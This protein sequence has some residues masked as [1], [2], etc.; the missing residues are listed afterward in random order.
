MSKVNLWALIPIAVVVLMGL[1][2]AQKPASSETPLK[3]T[4]KSLD[5]KPLE[6]VAVS[7]RFDGTTNV[8]TSVFTARD[9]G[10]SFPPL[11][12]PLE[13]GQYKVWAQAVGF[14]AGR[15]G[16]K[17]SAG[18]AVEQNFALKPLQDFSKQLSGAEWMA[19][20]PS[21]TP[22]DRRLTRLLGNNCMQCHPLNFVLQNRFDAAGWASIVD[23]MAVISHDG[24]YRPDAHPSPWI[25]GYK[26]EM[27]AYLARVRG[28]GSELTY[29]PL[30]RATGEATQ[31]VVTEFDIFPGHLP[32]V[33]PVEN[34]S[35]WSLGTPA[36]H[37]NA[38]AHDAVVDQNGYVWFTDNINP[39]RTIGKLDPRTGRITDYAL[40][41]E[42][43]VA[44]ATHDG[45]VDQKGDIWISSGGIEFGGGTVKFDPR[46]EK[47]HQF[48]K[49]DSLP[50]CCGSLMAIDSK[51]NVWNGAN[52]G[53]IRKVDPKSGIPY[54][55]P[56]PNRKGGA[57]KL[58][59]KTGEYTF[60]RAISPD[61]RNYGVAIDAEDNAWFTQPGRNQLG[62][63]NA[64]N[65]EVGEVNLG[66][67]GL[68]E[69]DIEHTALDRELA[70]K[71]EPTAGQ[72]PP[73][74]KTPRRQA[75]DKRG[76]LWVALSSASRLAKIDIHT[77]KVTEYPMP[78]RYSWPYKVAVDKNHMLWVNGMN[79][80][81]IF[82]FNPF[83]EQWTSYPLPTL[84]TESRFI[85]V[86]NSTD[87]PTVWLPSFRTNKLIRVQFRTG[88]VTRTASR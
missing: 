63:V 84:G 28:P 61:A 54:S 16:A 25:H 13:E 55:V 50:R 42:N 9:G 14:E 41:G 82:K 46:T 83:T 58:N 6:G 60:Y 47:F 34:G 66:P 11:V 3:G 36:R 8:T 20:L 76:N 31:I 87:P 64:R 23:L 35:D 24:F 72:G 40:R 51:G 56:D 65:G 26:E 1:S 62:V 4:V 22:Q 86:D 88:A 74:Q 85:S 77:R 69:D 18:K 32:G 70:A 52:A 2:P 67:L 45:A 57:M 71:F 53:S 15:S 81:R 5:G 43:N 38:A 68:E 44:M 21:A 37:E 48:P 39:E 59:P 30:P 12:P 49:P 29:K 27:V 17:L 19:S 79:T 7:M 10:Y 80:D 78:S 33:L 73:W 75:A